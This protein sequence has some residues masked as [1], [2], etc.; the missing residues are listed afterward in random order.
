MPSYH[1]VHMVNCARR[2]FCSATGILWV[3]S[4]IAC[5][6]LGH[7]HK[8]NAYNHSRSN[9]LSLGDIGQ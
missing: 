6:F 4:A 8:D 1:I 2:Y 5:L 9:D 3:N 7:T